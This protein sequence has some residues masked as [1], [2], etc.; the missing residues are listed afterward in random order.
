MKESKPR[1]HYRGRYLS[2]VER[3][4]WEFATR[5]TPVVAVLVA[6]LD[7]DRLVLVEQ[8]RTPIQRRAIEL[9]AGLVGDLDGQADESPCAAGARELVEE[10]GYRAARLNEIMRCP[11]SAGMSDETVVFLAASGLSRVGCGGGDASEDITVHTVALDQIDDWLNRQ[12]A[13]GKAI[14]PKIYC[15]LYW[16]LAARLTPEPPTPP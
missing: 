16:K 6:W 11:T 5:A 13:A 14:D 12:Q 9:P 10:T 8:F 1:I 7:D 3:D 2:L 15:A 4:G